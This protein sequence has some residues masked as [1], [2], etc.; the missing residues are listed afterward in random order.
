MKSLFNDNR[1]ANILILLRRTQAASMEMLVSVL[2]VGDRTIR[3]DIR[4]INEEMDGCASIDNIKGK[5]ILR[6]F[7]EEKFR[8]KFSELIQE[9]TLLNSPKNRRDYIFA[10]LM[11]AEEMVL[12]DELAYEMNVGRTTMVSDL[13]KLRSDVEEYK[14]SVVGK[15]SKGICLNGAEIDIR[16]YVIENNYDFCYKDYPMDGDIVEIIDSTLKKCAFEKKVVES[17]RKFTTLMLDRF[18]TGHYIGTLLPA[19]YN[20]TSKPEFALINEMVEQ[21]SGILHMD[22]PVEERI[23]IFL[24]IVGMRTPTDIRDMHQIEL[25]ENVRPLMREILLRIKT[26]M[27]ITI[28]NGEFTEEFLYHLM[29][30]INRLKFRVKLNNP[31]LEDIKHK[32]PLAWQMAEVA[33]EVIHEYSGLEVS[34]EEKGYLASYFGVFLTQQE[35]NKNVPFSIAVV[36]GTGRV[37]ARL[38]AVQLKKILDNTA[39][40]TFFSDEKVSEEVLNQFDLVITTVNLD[41]PCDRP[42]IQINEIFNEKELLNKIDKVRY[43]DEVEVPLMDN[44]WFVMTGLLDES[45][46]FYLNDVSTYEEA[47]AKMVT[48][49]TESNQ[50][51]EGFFERLCERESKGTMVFDRSIAI[52]HSIQYVD[53]RIVLAIGVTDQPLTYHG[54]EISLIF[55]LGLPD[56]VNEEDKLLLRVYD[57]LMTIATDEE[58]KNNIMESK[59]YSTLLRALYRNVEN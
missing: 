8:K 14:L 45:R 31:L 5:Y 40:M 48:E 28:K 13:K 42:I 21:I 34:E 30:M 18:L 47:V 44:N 24:P 27:N 22:I 59:E 16:K 9:D 7:H 39:E 3:N 12:T 52:P 49:L 41:F 56:T 29:F 37:T 11:R 17:V 57:E 1:K 53:D 58:L 55:L 54:Y 4:Q 6:I 36:C 23:Y 43:W 20:L 25:D 19:Y 26:D 50:L 33:K 15:T 46:F 10:K 38:V 35:M 32:Y 51:D 2:N